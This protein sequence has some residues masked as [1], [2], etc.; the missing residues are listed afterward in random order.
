MTLS[1]C[2]YAIPGGK[3]AAT[4]PGI[5]LSLP[6][7]GRRLPI[8]AIIF[9]LVLISGLFATEMV[10][11]QARAD[12]LVVAQQQKR[13]TLFDF[14]FGKQEPEPEAAA[15]KPSTTS[16]Q[17]PS[18]SVTSIDQIATPVEKVPNATRLAV[19]GDSLAVD[20]A[21]AMERAH[22]EDPN[23]VVLGEGKGSSGFVRDDFYDWN[24][25]L[26][27]YIAQ[28][29]FDIAVVIIGINDR[30]PIGD[31]KPL[32]DDWKTA[33]QARLAE[34]LEQLRTAN[35]PVIWVGLPPMRGPNYSAAMIQITSIQK[36]AAF[37]G[38]A[39]F[40]DIYD[41]FVG[42]NGG[43]TDY[44][45]DL[46]GANTLMRKSDG[47]HI[48]AAGSDKV[49]F[50]VDQALKRFYQGGAVTL[51]VA[52]VLAGTDAE[53]MVRMP[54]QGLGQIRM[55][56]VAGAVLPLGEERVKAEQLV[57]GGTSGVAGFTLEQMVAAPVGR[58][59]AFGV[60]VEPDGG[61]PGGL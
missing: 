5:A 48:S 33:Y 28:D 61:E 20:L 30:Q 44:G 40:V 19:F 46:N 51:D 47:I 37:A 1:R 21:R 60:G 16:P 54:F 32:T 53:N 24:S 35:K 6:V 26:A 57:S 56:E 27:A 14:L 15:Q 3:P 36:L 11:A 31:M 13:A 12:T 45:P 42:E 49:A 29:A 17:K 2:F 43:Y 39:E 8:R 25:E 50:Y 22:V 9:G 18:P 23:L 41:R 55:V 52:D 34:F 4:F 58:A 38:G 10:L 59:D 7:T